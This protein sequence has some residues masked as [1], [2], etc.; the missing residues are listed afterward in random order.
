MSITHCAIATAGVS[1]ILGT[2]DPLALF[3]GVV[4]SQLPDID[5]ST[6]TIGKIFFP[7][8]GWIEDRYPHRTITHS[9]LATL[10]IAAFSA[11]I[12]FTTKNHLWAALALG[13]LLACFS[14]CFTKQGVQIFYPYPVWAVSVANPRRRIT[15]GSAPELMILSVAIVLFLIGVHAATGGGITQNVIQ[16]LGM[17][18][19]AVEVYN[20]KASSNHIYAQ[21][22]GIWA[23]DRTRVEGRF[24]IAGVEGNEFIVSDAR[25]IYQTG[26]QIIADRVTPTLGSP[27]TTQVLSIAFNDEEIAPKLQEAMSSQPGALILLSGQIVVDVP[28]RVR[29]SAIPRQLNTASMSGSTVILNFHPIEQALQQLSDQYGTGTLTLKV[30][31]PRPQ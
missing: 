29:F 7:I 31:S 3:L 25:G 1:L 26:K 28:E 24:F 17:K 11:V 18:E 4:G 10:G 14:D 16:A 13:H 30:I 27:A 20:Q 12:G 22:S 19:A 21:I 23:D 6:S 5:T 15:T 2:A 8:S 9:L